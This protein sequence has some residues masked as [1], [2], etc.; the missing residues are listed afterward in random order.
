ML[1][2]PQAITV[3]A[4]SQSMPLISREGTHSFYQKGD[5][6][7][8]LDVKHRKVVR[9]KKRR[10][11]HLVTFTQRKVIADPLTAV[12]DYETLSESV[13]F[14][15]PEVGFTSTEVDQMWAGLKTWFD[16]TKV[17]QIYNRES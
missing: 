4:V 3:N 1:A 15:R 12:N 17:G 7:F 13:Q 9:D 16:T 11:V 8:S 5:L 14:D 10:D 2:D 6:T